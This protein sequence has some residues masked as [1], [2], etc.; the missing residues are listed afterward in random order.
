[1][2]SY[3]TN[4]LVTGI[5]GDIGIGIIDILKEFDNCALLVGCD[6]DSY[7]ASRKDIDHFY[8][9]PFASEEELFLKFVLDLCRKH[10][11]ELII[12]STEQEL[13]VLSNN[14]EL[15]ENNNIELLINSSYIIDTFLDKFKTI[16][17]FIENGISYPRTFRVDNIKEQLEFPLIL[18]L[19]ESS[20]GKGVF[21]INDT[22]DLEYYTRRYPNSIIQEHIGEE[23]QEYTVGV[24]SDGISTYSIA[25][26]RQL[27][28][29]GLSKKARLVSDDKLDQLVKHIAKAANLKG[30]IN[31][32]LRRDEHGNYIPFEINPRLSSTLAFREYFG[33]SDLKWWIDLMYD[34]KIS[35]KATYKKGIGVKTV[36]ETYFEMEES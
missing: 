23:D 12:P 17:F 21:I 18:K 24:F 15:F 16:D 30:S 9:A 10:D 8:V 29:G 4:I 36:A 1:M 25:F 27:G 28:L 2:R 11:I 6:I 31:I 14:R 35:Y 22:L 34:H 13:K 3:S 26:Q 33:F 5:G 19:I 20:G 32:Q 7:P